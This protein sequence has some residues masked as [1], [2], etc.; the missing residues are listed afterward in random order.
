MDDRSAFNAAQRRVAELNEKTA[1]E[2]NIIA[3]SQAKI[4]S[5]EKELA[6]LQSWLSMWHK[7]MG[8]ENPTAVERIVPNPPPRIRRPK[9]PDREEVVNH[10]LEIIRD[11]NEPQSRKQLFDELA[12]LGLIIRGKDPE[13]VLSTML[14]RSQDRIVRLPN[15]GYWPANEQYSPAGYFPHLDRSQEMTAQEPEGGVEADDT[16]E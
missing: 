4:A 10:T 8:T 12:S 16:D 2:K 15:F 13:M 9:N 11:R 1:K 3:D 14:W 7:L 5:Y 6:D